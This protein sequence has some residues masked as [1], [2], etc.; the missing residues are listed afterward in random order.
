MASPMAE[1][2]FTMMLLVFEAT[3]DVLI[4]IIIGGF[5]RCRVGCRDYQIEFGTYGLCE[6]FNPYTKID[7]LT[8]FMYIGVEFLPIF[9][10]VFS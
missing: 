9:S 4:V 1:A 8:T 7:K 5:S 3:E 10:K 2:I 6:K